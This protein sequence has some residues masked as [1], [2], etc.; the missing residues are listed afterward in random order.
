M[1]TTL[2]LL[3]YHRRRKWAGGC[4]FAHQATLRE[5][6]ADPDASNRT[7]AGRVKPYPVSHPLVADVRSR[8]ASGDLVLDPIMLA[9]ADGEP[10]GGPLEALIERRRQRLETGRRAA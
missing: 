9:M 6:L 1:T 5:V 3:W 7:L 8:F 10:T 4:S 2:D